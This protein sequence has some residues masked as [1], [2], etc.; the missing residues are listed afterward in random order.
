M[1][2]GCAESIKSSLVM[3]GNICLFLAPPLCYNRLGR[4]MYGSD[5]A[6]SFEKRGIE[7]TYTY[8]RTIP[9]VMDTGVKR[10]TSSELKN[11]EKTA[12][13]GTFLGFSGRLRFF[14]QIACGLLGRLFRTAKFS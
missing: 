11:A 9:T 5:Q 3:G 7:V 6:A 10:T 1:G 4:A 8:I 2:T 12:I 13:L 14:P